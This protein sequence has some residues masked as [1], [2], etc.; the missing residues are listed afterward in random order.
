MFNCVT[1]VFTVFLFVRIGISLV[2]LKKGKRKKEKN[3]L[4]ISGWGVLGKIL[5]SMRHDARYTDMRVKSL[6]DLSGLT[7]NI[8]ATFTR[9]TNY[10]VCHLHIYL[11]P[12]PS[13]HITSPSEKSGPETWPGKHMG[14]A[15][16][17]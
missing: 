2:H 14:K 8:Y 3:L 16:P 10:Q 4:N 15:T 9:T 17:V 1:E 6:R 5:G 13:R 7:C 12:T 11:Y